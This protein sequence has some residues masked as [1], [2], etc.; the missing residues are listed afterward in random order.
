MDETLRRRMLWI[1]LVAAA[2]FFLLSLLLAALGALTSGWYLVGAAVYGAVFVVAIIGFATERGPIEATERVMVLTAQPTNGH[3]AEVVEPVVTSSR[4]RVLYTTPR[5][6]VLESST[7]SSDGTSR[8]GYAV[9]TEGRR[10]DILDVESRVDERGFAAGKGEP[11]S[12]ELRA[13][14]LRWGRIREVE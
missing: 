6:Q 7:A 13:G 2:G 12:S 11:S 9:E 3:S 8:R 1:A 5:G 10:A 4:E 14:L